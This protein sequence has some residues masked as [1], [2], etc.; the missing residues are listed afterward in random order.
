MKQMLRRTRKKYATGLLFLVPALVVFGLFQWL[1]ILGNLVLAFSSYSPGFAPVWN[2]LGNFIR[3]FNDPRFLK[4]IFNTLKYV[5]VCL[6][7]GYVVPII[8]AL[9]ISEIRRGRGFFRMA[10]YTPNILPA[11]ATYI[12]WR[13]IFNPQ[14]GLLNMALGVFGVEPQLW[15]LDKSQVIFSIALM[16]T[17]QGFGSTAV[18]YMASLS[19]VNSELYESA[20]MEGAGFLRRIW[21]ITLPS[22]SGTMKL[23]LVL[24]LIAT[25]QVL[26]EPFVVT[27][28]GPNDASLTIMLLTYQ[29]A[30]E[31]IDFGR[32]GAVG[33]LLLVAMIGLS[34]FYV[35]RTGLADPKGV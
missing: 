1:P 4:A 19:S 28:G 16:A 14:F 20:E 15:L 21:S 10:I 31:Y 29:Y 11:I 35:R 18:L 32:A 27:S 3:V 26:Q 9:A 2:G 33:L 25:F 7:M 30:F 12:I 6:L 5:G 23:L 8:V 24:Q 17:W 34:I 22:I 13:W